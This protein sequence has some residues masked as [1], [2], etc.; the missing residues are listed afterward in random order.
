[1]KSDDPKTYSPLPP[2]KWW[3]MVG[4]YLTTL[5]S[6]ERDTDMTVL[7]EVCFLAQEVMSFT[8]RTGVVHCLK[9]KYGCWYST[10]YH[11]QMSQQYCSQD[12]MF[13]L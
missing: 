9:N 8:T 6:C 11:H 12:E 13:Q 1:V 10:P 7:T 5:F 4:V 3:H 2:L